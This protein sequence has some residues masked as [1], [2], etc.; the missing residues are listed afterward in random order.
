MIRSLASE[1]NEKHFK[2]DLRTF[3]YREMAN[4]EEIGK[5]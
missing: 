1:K 3:K 5:S 2:N 4:L